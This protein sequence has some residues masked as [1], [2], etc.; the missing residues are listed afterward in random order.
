MFGEWLG[1][2]FLPIAV[3][4]VWLGYWMVSRSSGG[5]YDRDVERQR[6]REDRRQSEVDKR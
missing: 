4:L 5:R 2:L 6:M 1:V 3:A